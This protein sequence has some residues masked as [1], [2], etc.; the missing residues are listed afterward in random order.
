MRDLVN[1]KS[2]L[3]RK[4]LD[5]ILHWLFPRW[6]VPLYTSVTFSRMRYHQCIENRRWQDA[7]LTRISSVGGLVSLLAVFFLARRK[8]TSQAL[9]DMALIVFNH[10]PQ[11]RTL[12]M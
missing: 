5:G 2:F 1:K 10:V 7:A 6:W 4:K 11:L 8:A 12:R 3:L 9:Q